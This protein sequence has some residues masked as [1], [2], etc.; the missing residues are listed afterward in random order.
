VPFILAKW[1]QYGRHG[2]RSIVTCLRN[3]D[4]KYARDYLVEFVRA[5]VEEAITA[6]DMNLSF[7]CA[8]LAAGVPAFDEDL[9]GKLRA[10]VSSGSLWH[11]KLL[12]QLCEHQVGWKGEVL[13]VAEQAGPCESAVWVYCACASDE[14]VRAALDACFGADLE[15]CEQGSMEALGAIEFPWGEAPELVLKALRRKNPRLAKPVL[16]SVRDQAWRVSIEPIRE[17]LEW[18]LDLAK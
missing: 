17:W 16:D 7:H 4:R 12:R 5:D 13:H 11:A 2:F 6:L 8:D 15:A 18:M 9:F 14:D 10:N 1:R 3:K